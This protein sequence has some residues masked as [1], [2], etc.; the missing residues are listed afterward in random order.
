MIGKPATGQV[1]AVDRMR[2]LGIEAPALF[3]G[4]GIQG[5][6]QVVR[7]AQVEAVVDLQRSDLVGGLVRSSGPRR[8][9]VW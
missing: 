2:H 1:L 4:L 6:H 8:S 7:R 9:P 5:D 3:A